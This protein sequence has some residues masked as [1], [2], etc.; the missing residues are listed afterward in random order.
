M[1]IYLPWQPS[2]GDIS[3]RSA[4]EAMFTNLCVDAPSKRNKEIPVHFGSSSRDLC[5]LTTVAP[6]FNFDSTTVY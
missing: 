5:F 3:L 1:A 4:V 2:A 6:A